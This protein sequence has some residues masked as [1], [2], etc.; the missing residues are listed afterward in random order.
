MATHGDRSGVVVVT[1]ATGMLGSATAT[2]LARRAVS[3]DLVARN[4]AAGHQLLDSVK[5][6][7]GGSHRL[8][9][10]DLSE[11]DSVRAVAAEISSGASAV[12]A[13]VHSAAALFRDRR[14][15]SVGHEAMFATNVLARFLLT[16]ELQPLLTTGTPGRVINVTGPSPDTLDFANLMAETRFNA[17]RQFRATN[18]ANLQ[19]AFELAR[20]GK[21]IGLTANAYTPGAL[22][23][24]LMGQMPAPVRLLTLP[25]G[26]SADR[27]AAALADLTVGSEHANTTGE[28]YKRDQPA[29]APRASLD[30]ESQRRLW[31][32]CARL[33]ALD[34][35]DAGAG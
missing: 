24:D 35:T 2:A 25:F 11:P 15:N 30:T 23:S 1:G 18:A 19:L 32:E 27:A 7:G 31:V 9:I 6:A 8:V 22:Q 21:L 26:R 13:V 16:H 29:R 33:L 10:G 20:R 4:E 34:L 28:F 5:R 12:A 3:T 14:V 17:F